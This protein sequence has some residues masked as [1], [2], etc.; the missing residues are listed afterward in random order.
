V[1]LA[2]VLGAVALCSIGGAAASRTDN[3]TLNIVFSTN[4]TDYAQWVIAKDLGFYDTEGVN[5]NDSFNAG[6]NTINL[7]VSGQAD[8]AT[9]TGAGAAQVA[10]QGKPVSGIMS[11][12]VNPG[13]ALSTAPGITSLADLKNA[14]NCRWAVAAAGSQAYWQALV[15]QR[16]LG[17]ANKCTLVQLATTPLQIQGIVS[18]AYQAAVTGLTSVIPFVSQGVHILINPVSPSYLST[19]GRD[20]YQAGLIWGLKDNLQSKSAAVVAYIRGSFDASQYLWTHNDKQVA[21]Q[22]LKNPLYAG[23]T[24][25]Q[26][27]AFVAY[28]RPFIGNN[29]S[30]SKGGSLSK[31]NY[32]SAAD[33]KQA[34]TVF[35]QFGLSGFDTSSSSVQY[36][37][38][39]DMSYWNKAFPK[40]NLVVDAKHRTLSQLAAANL[41]SAAKWNQLYSA[42]KV[43]LDALGLKQS[44]IPNA[45]LRIGTVVAQTDPAR[46]V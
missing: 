10:L 28:N 4:V 31:P 15:Y 26:M 7:V 44:Q 46:G 43:W 13:A 34:M 45:K 42:N 23:N 9:Y 20:L 22:L 38:I 16:E 24:L 8:L 27:V 19:Y 40:P 33:W 18:G 30:R 2:L 12:E 25:D 41:G 32:M 3:P 36:P 37:A 5:V 6:S 39:I 29:T 17:L 14:T 35:G 21:E 1:V 11:S